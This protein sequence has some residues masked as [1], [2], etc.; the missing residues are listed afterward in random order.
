MASSPA[1][2]AAAHTIRNSGTDGLSSVS[3]QR[4]AR[5]LRQVGAL[6]ARAHVRARTLTLPAR[7]G[8]STI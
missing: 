3:N 2:L 8:R 4:Q 7:C 5:L 6:G 1:L